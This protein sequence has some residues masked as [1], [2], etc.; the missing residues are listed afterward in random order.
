MKE[1][2]YTIPVSEAFGEK[3][4]CP[5]C[6]LYDMLESREIEAITG[7]AMMEPDVR[8]ETNRLGFCRDHLHQM[9][10]AKNRLS[11]A[12][13]LETHLKETLGLLDPD[14]LPKRGALEAAGERLMKVDSTCYV[15]GRIEGHLGKITQVILHLWRTEPD[16]RRLFLEQPGFCLPH[17]GRLLQAAGKELPK[18]ERPAFLEDAL[19]VQR[20]YMGEL[21]GDVEWFCKKFDYRYEKED[22]KNSKDAVE[23]AVG[24]LTSRKPK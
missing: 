23:R 24:M 2:I 16:F 9:F 20:R 22:W 3:K 4:G 13:V 15:C 8:I 14:K 5:M 11:L 6:S 18:K 12:L 10:G 7:A 19:T 17:F 1:T 21:I